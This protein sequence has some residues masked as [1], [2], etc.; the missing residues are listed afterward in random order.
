MEL[1]Y[2]KL[3]LQLRTRVQSKYLTAATAPGDPPI[4]QVY[5]AAQN[6]LE[7]VRSTLAHAYPQQPPDQILRVMP[8]HAVKQVSV[9][10]ALLGV[11]ALDAAAQ[12]ATAPVLV[13]Q[14]QRLRAAHPA[15]QHFRLLLINAFGSNLG[16]N[17]IGLTAFRQLLGVLREHLPAVSV[18]VLLGWHPD[19]RLVRLFRDIDGIDQVRTQGFTLAELMQYQGLFDTSRLICLPRYGQMPMADWYLWWLGLDPAGI[20]PQAKR[21]AVAIPEADR[22]WVAQHLPPANGPRILLNPKASVALRS[23]PEDALRRLVDAL[24]ADWPQAQIILVQPLA[25]AHGRVSHLDEVINTIDRLAA[26]VAAVD[27]LI[28]VD[29]YT[30]HLA[31]ATAT[32]AVT[33]F[34]SIHPDSFPYYPLAHGVCLPH[35]AQ[36]PGWNMPKVEPQAWGAMAAAYE[37]AWAAL[38]CAE[39]LAAL[40]GVMAKKA[41]A[42]GVFGQGLL[43]PRSAPPVCPTR[44]LGA[45]AQALEV[46]LRQCDDALAKVLD[47]TLVSLATQVLCTGDTVVHLAPGVGESALPLARCVGHQ[48]RLVAIEPRRHLHQMLCANLARADIWHAQT[49]WALPEGVG[50]LRFEMKGLRA[51]D[52]FQS[53]RLFNTQ[54]TEAVVCWP[55]DA[56]ALDSCRLL[57]LQSPLARVEVL[58]GASETLARMR[59][60]VLIGLLALPV[61]KDLEAFF[62]GL[63]YGLR[64]APLANVDATQQVAAYGILVAEP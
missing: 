22:Q 34:S 48:G 27:G 44:R 35:A 64:V 23:M 29:T 45:D 31:D 26:L 24:L 17:L 54:Q 52:E 9:L 42:P 46:P 38:D 10:P 63:S 25:L 55:L 18:D 32:P 6:E 58:K 8:P 11:A 3:P 36:L 20:A 15:R 5:V 1:Y 12:E 59:P 56:L 14:L 53:L 4:T 33:V 37:S 57:V 41:A 50:L 62:E 39:V 60:V 51:M 30:A 47:D 19:D 16:D 13:A 40:R 43:A 49:H 61:A 21:N 2:L 7:L 28:G